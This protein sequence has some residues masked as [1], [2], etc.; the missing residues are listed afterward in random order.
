MAGASARD[1]GS[2]RTFRRSGCDTAQAALDDLDKIWALLPE[3]DRAVA[4][5]AARLVPRAPRAA[6]SR[7]P[8]LTSGSRALRKENLFPLA[9]PGLGPYAQVNRRRPEE[10]RGGAAGT[11]TQDRRIMSPLL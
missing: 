4:E 2:R 9:K 6:A 7:A 11:R 3:L 8:G 1:D 10:D 5:W